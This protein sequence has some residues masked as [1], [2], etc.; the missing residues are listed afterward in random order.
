MTNETLKILKERRS[1]RKYQDKQISDEEL[2]AILEAGTWAATAAGLQPAVMVV[3]QDKETLSMLSR[4]N[5]EIQGNPQGRSLL[6][7]SHRRGGA[8]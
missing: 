3:V 8:G 1:I 6:R 7:R 2:D 5:A 4:A